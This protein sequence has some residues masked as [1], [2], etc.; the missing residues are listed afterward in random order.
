MSLPGLLQAITPGIFNIIDQAVADK[1]LAL[2]LKNE[3]GTAFL[4]MQ[5]EVARAAADIVVA[6]AKGENW[7]Q[8]NWRPALMVWFA[9]LVGAYWFGFVPVNMPEEHVSALFDLV[10]LGVSGYV[11]GRSG[12]KIATRIGEAVSAGMGK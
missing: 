12:E 6:E 7:L 10:T 9:F 5:S 3:L 11:I 1:D 8:R 2:R 4:N